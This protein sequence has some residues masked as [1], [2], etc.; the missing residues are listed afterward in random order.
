M[1]KQNNNYFPQEITMFTREEVAELFKTN[2]DF[3]STLSE[4]EILRPI[5][6]GK[7]YMFP[8]LSLLEFE[9]DFQ[10]YDLS[11]A[12]KAQESRKAVELMKERVQV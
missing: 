6:I 11:N 2:V 9:K 12:V 8:F 3:I 10:G 7:R 5:K 4:L 1:L